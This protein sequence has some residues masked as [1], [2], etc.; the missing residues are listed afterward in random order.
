[1]KRILVADDEDQIRESV[2]RALEALGYEIIEA[3]N[4]TSALDLARSKKP[5]LIISDVVMDN[6]SGFLLR[7]LLRE[8]EETSMIPLILMTGHAHRAGAWGSDPDIE[9]LEK[10]FSVAELGSA[11]ERQLKRTSRK[12]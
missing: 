10:P 7:E 1:M 2:R 5:H 3:D 12:Q 8:D 6:G 4:G 11:V 9:Y